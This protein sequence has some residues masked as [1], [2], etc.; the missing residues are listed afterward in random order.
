MP[1]LLKAR[2]TNILSSYPE[3]DRCLKKEGPG[4]ADCFLRQNTYTS[5]TRSSNLPPYLEAS[6]FTDLKRRGRLDMIFSFTLWI[7]LLPCLFCG[8]KAIYNLFLHPLRSYPGPW[9]TRSSSWPWFYQRLRGNQT[10]WLDRLHKQYGTIVR[11]APDHL[12]YIDPESWE[13]MYGQKASS[14]RE[15]QSED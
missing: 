4:A 8:G 11:V 7:C 14:R 5:K 3:F 12:S 13:D 6:A 10:C 15:N 9:Y 2:G 1:S